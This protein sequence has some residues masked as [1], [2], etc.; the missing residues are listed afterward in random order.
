M[1]AGPSLDTAADAAPPSG[2]LE[3]FSFEWPDGKIRAISAE[4]A[5]LL[6]VTAGEVNGRPLSE[7][8]HPA[9]RQRLSLMLTA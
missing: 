6:G 2:E 9:D 8:V 3:L 1:A 5:S 7:L 4:F